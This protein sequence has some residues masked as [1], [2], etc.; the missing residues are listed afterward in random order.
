MRR[1]EGEF[2]IGNA[3]VT[4]LHRMKTRHLALET[5]E[6]RSKTCNVLESKMCKK[7]PSGLCYMA[8][9]FSAAALCKKLALQVGPCNIARQ[10]LMEKVINAKTA[11]CNLNIFLDANL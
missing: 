8:M 10:F 4:N 1:K 9:I 2:Q 3:H 11:A 5:F 6:V 7:S